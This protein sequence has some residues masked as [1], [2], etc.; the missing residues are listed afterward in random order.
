M[1]AA[2]AQYA[3]SADNKVTH[4]VTGDRYIASTIDPD[5]GVEVSK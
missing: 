1:R 2:I 5:M 4:C 3:V